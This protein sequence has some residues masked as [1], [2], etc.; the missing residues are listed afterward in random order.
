MI[1]DLP[2]GR[3]LR[4]FRRLNGIKQGHVAELLD[5]SQGSVSR[6]E[7]GAHEPETCHRDRIVAMIAANANNDADAALRRLVS[8]STLAVHLVCDATHRLLAAS[9]SRVASWATSEDKYLGQSLWRFASPE[10]VVAEAGLRDHG[11]F[12]RPC[13]RLQFE[14]GS[15]DSDIVIVHPSLMQWETVP[16]SDGRIGR[17]TTTID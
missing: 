15:N 10:I 9:P 1:P 2:V 4:R 5:V 6:W 16:L 12:E 7:S 17:L 11:W 8:S 13:Q 3:A 14:T